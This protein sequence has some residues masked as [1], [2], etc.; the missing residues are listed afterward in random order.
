MKKHFSAQCR[1]ESGFTIISLAGELD[2]ESASAELELLGYI[3][4]SGPGAVLID[5]SALDYISSAGVSVFLSLSYACRVK[6]VPIT[7]FR[8]RPKI[9]DVLD[10]IGLIRIF[11]V[12]T[13]LEDAKRIHRRSLMF[14]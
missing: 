3:A 11:S 9:Q 14:C 13:T 8:L 5:C 1:A 10:I 4:A 7:F 12:A 6:N 2:A